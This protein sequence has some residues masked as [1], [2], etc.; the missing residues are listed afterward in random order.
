MKC[1]FI[2]AI[3]MTFLGTCWTQTLNNSFLNGHSHNDYFQKQP[4]VTAFEAGM[5]S[6]ETDVFLWN[7]NLY[8]AHTLFEIDWTCTFEALYVQPVV[9]AVR[10]GKAYPMQLMIDVKT[11]AEA[12]LDIITRELARYPD[13]F[14]D[15]SMIKIVISGNRPTPS[16]WNK[17]PSYIQFDGRPNEVYTSEQWQRVGLVSDNFNAYKTTWWGKDILCPKTCERLKKVLNYVHS[18]GK[19]MRFW[20][21]PDN[22]AAWEVLTNLGVDFIN[23]DSPCALK[24][25]FENKAN[26]AIFSLK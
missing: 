23:T 1:I 11:G 22:K 25:F 13:V 15:K 21:T 19:K 9:Y 7:Q 20:K 8:V 6:I 14:N 26:E 18:K 2:C 10:S 12:T 3:C 16:V 24:S 4:F 17:Y 5:T